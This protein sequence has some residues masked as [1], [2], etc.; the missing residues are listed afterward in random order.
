MEK[1]KY[2]SRRNFIKLS[3][4]SAC[5]AAVCGCKSTPSAKDLPE[6]EETIKLLAPDGSLV[7]VSKAQITPLPDDELIRGQAA[8][9]GIEG[10][11]FVMVIDLARCNNARKCVTACQKMHHQP[12]DKEWLQVRL[13]NDSEQAAPYWFPKTCFHCD[14][15][16]CVK[17][18][19][20]DATF[21]RDDGLVLIDNERCIG[22][23]FCMAACPYSTRVFNW[24]E[25]QQPEEIANCAPSP[26]TSVPSKIGTVDK[27]DFCPDM[28]RRG[29]LPDCVTACPNGV[30]Y[31]GDEVEDT[32]TNGEETI[33]F[34]QLIADRAG[35]RYMEELGTKPRVYYLPPRDR[36]FP[37]ERGMENLSDPLKEMFKEL[38]DEFEYKL[39]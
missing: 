36:I 10:R 26:E 4:V 19:P 21:K 29:L 17:V 38:F 39:K 25:P 35:Y 34:S 37:V 3:V 11:K 24:D 14:N 12:E 18:C 20:V 33:R 23:K 31:F 7:E 13:M 32:V 27:C 30:F 2:N 22:C 28:A 9:M 8:R 16:P 5:G 15:P 1:D 6:N